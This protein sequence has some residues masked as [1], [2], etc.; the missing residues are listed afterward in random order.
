LLSS[1]LKLK[2]FQVLTA[3]DG[4]EAMKII[5]N[6]LID[7]L[8]SDIYMP[9]MDGLELVQGLREKG[10]RIPVVL[11]SSMDST[12]QLAL[13]VGADFFVPKMDSSQE[14]L[15]SIAIFCSEIFGSENIDDPEDLVPEMQKFVN[16]AV[17][18][19]SMKTDDNIHSFSSDFWD[20][21]SS[22]ISSFEGELNASLRKKSSV[23]NIHTFDS[24][25]C[26]YK[27]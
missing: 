20:A 5:N 12:R 10:N 15:G 21:S 13:S 14:I 16:Q 24:F 2:G 6:N 25:S 26:E 27:N 3:E 7:L 22:K 11:I 19:V 1:G 9:N 18:Q 4:I 8:I 23:D 17:T